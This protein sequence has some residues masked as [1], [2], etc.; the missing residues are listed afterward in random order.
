MRHSA[1]ALL[2]ALCACG[3][4]GA[5][6]SNSNTG[7]ATYGAIALTSHV[8]A[9]DAVQVPLDTTITLRFDAR[10]V[11]DCTR[12]PDTWLRRSG[13]TEDVDGTWS[14]ADSGRQLVFTPSAPLLPETDYDVSVSPLTCDQEGRILEAATTFS[15]RTIDQ[16]PPTVASANVS[17]NQ[18][19]RSRTAPFVVTTSEALAEASVTANSVLLRDVYN[20]RY[21]CERTLVGNQLQVRPLADLPGDRRFT[22]QVNASVTDRAGNALPSVW[23]CSFWTASDA[24][25]P[26]ATS[27]WPSSGSTDVSPYVQPIVTFDEAMDPNT[28]EPSSLLFQDEFGGYVAYTVVASAD[29]RTLRVCPTQPLASNRGYVLA[30]LVS[31]AAVTDVSG[32]ALTATTPLSFRTGADAVPLQVQSSVPATQSTRVSVNAEP[33]IVFAEDLDPVWATDGNVV[34]ECLGE[35]VPAVL[36]RP[37]ANTV[38][39]TPVLPL[40]PS[41]TYTVW[42]RGGH[43]G[44]RDRAGNVMPSDLQLVFS[45]ADDATI[46]TAMLQPSDGAS[47]LAT[48]MHASLVFSS[49]LDPATVTSTNFELRTDSGV[50]VPTTIDLV[51]SDRVVV[52][53]PT[54]QLTANTYYRTF[55]RGGASGVREASGNW[56]AHDLGAR[57]RTTSTLD[58]TPP[59]VT[60]TVNAIDTAR[61]S[62]LLL[63]TSGFTIDVDAQDG[64]QAPDIGS[65]TIDLAGPGLAPDPESLYAD[66]VVGFRS[67]RVV[68]PPT[69]GLVPGTWTMNV[70]VRDLAGNVGVATPVTF[71]LAEPNG[72]LVPFE[73]TQVVW[74]RTD[75]DRDGNGRADF[76]DDMLR[77]GLATSGDP[78]GTNAYVRDVA[79]DAILARAND[80][81]GRGSRGEPIDR[82]SV[83][84]R[85]TPFE[86]VGLPHMQIAVGG[87]DPQGNRTRAFGDQTTGVLGRA[88][89]DYRNGNTNDR[90]VGTSPGLG[91]FPAEMFLY[92]VDLH[93]QLY[94]SFLTMFAQRFLPLV[95]QMGGVPA[96]SHAADAVVLRE[97][98]DP[99]TA[100][101][102]QYARWLVVM[103]AIDDWAMVIGTVLAHEV[104]HAVGLTAP[105]PA[106]SG[107]FGDSSLHNMNASAAEVMAPAVG[108]EAM[109][110]LDY[111]F[112]DTNMA[113]LRH[114]ILLR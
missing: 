1:F 95:P 78:L 9:D 97:G 76:D 52:L 11:L 49:R 7:T 30:F 50:A 14:L 31:G 111:H 47:G 28:V 113:Y 90:N 39:L 86:P 33:T 67:L 53:T 99:N 61:R 79:R 45:T 5:G 74:T 12:H 110:S 4:Q 87:L 107:L 70:S 16:T 41:S 18:T 100:T 65:V 34:L 77:L 101:S 63:P 19:G 105:G 80:L 54:T 85:F 26:S 75:M 24:Q 66:A 98:F 103:R 38:V 29:Q 37:A 88:Y 68:V 27:V 106:P 62:G 2:T 46:P 17:P 35:T 91:V 108:Y 60:A 42:L 3:S 36:S 69:A 15:F 59:S 89:Y 64:L 23:S 71:T 21:D 57:W 6:G 81:Y 40:D 82:D 58:V 44:L 112:R 25:A 56:L 51:A 13:T 20:Q 73:R 72:G 10:M 55:V 92:Q 32:N 8:P 93:L 22:L 96:G 43:S 48:S 94:P 114:R 102:E 109:I 104:G 83:A 84:I